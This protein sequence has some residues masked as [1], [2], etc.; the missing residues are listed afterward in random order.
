[1]L[2]VGFLLCSLF[3][4]SQQGLSSDTA[5]YSYFSRL[6]AVP[7]TIE[8][9]YK[10]YAPGV[11]NNPCQQY[12]VELKKQLGL[13]ADRSEHKSRLLSMLAGRYDDESER[14]DF[15]KINLA[16]DKA[17]QAAVEKA[18]TS[19]FSAI[20]NYNRIVKDRIDSISPKYKGMELAKHQ[21]EIYRKELGV[22]I[23]TCKKLMLEVD[24]IMNAKGYNKQLLTQT[25]SAPYYIQLL[26]VRGLFFDR[27]MKLNDLVEGALAFVAAQVDNCKK[28]PELCK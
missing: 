3:C 28:Y 18:S 10:L 1:M 22:L 12:R 25:S 26:E 8:D 7:S 9:T 6:P 16:K 19:F 5:I 2:L 20:D 27:L 14:Y 24:K 23:N 11:K 17:L 21:Q 4:Q 13:L 15:T